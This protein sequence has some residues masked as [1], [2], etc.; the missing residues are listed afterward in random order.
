M[1]IKI[2]HDIK[3][4]L[5]SHFEYNDRNYSIYKLN[6]LSYNLVDEDEI[7]VRKRLTKFNSLNEIFCYLKIEE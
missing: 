3:Q 7:K 4:K 1:K 2:L 6:E 5:I